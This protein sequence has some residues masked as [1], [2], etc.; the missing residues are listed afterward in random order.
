[1]SKIQCY[2]RTHRKKWGLSQRELARLIGTKDGATISRLERLRRSP[3]IQAAF[4]IEI[5]FGLSLREM[6]PG[7]FSKVEDGLMRR[8]YELHEEL[9]GDSSPSTRIKLDLLESAMKRA[10]HRHPS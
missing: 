1:M 9:Q 10:G 6:F 2:L 5:L 4:A 3:G 7:A 8:A